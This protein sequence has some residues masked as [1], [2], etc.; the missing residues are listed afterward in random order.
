M[1]MTKKEMIKKYKK[2]ESIQNVTCAFIINFLIVIIIMSVSIARL[3]EVS[4]K[5][6][7][8]GE[9]NHIV[10][11]FNDNDT[12]ISPA[13]ASNFSRN[14]S[15][16]DK[17]A[18]AKI[19]MAEAEGESLETKV[20]VILTVLNRVYSENDYYPDTVKEV[21]FQKDNGIYQFS[22]VMPGGRWWRV[23]P[24]KEC[25]KAV[26]I[27]NKMKEDISMGALYFESCEGESWHSENL[28]FLFESDNMRFYK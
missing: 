28:E 11:E 4:E 17:Y 2:R 23:E 12:T 25:R 10:Y 3:I 6:E 20:Y 5:N 1:K 24:N 21:I 19:A 7:N 26:K 27:V 9:N 18:L 13:N 8:E 14:L 15:E 22:S 16:Q